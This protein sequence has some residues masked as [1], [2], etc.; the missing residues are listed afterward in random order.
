M[1]E[2]G[3][4]FDHDPKEKLDLTAALYSLCKDMYSYN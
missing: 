3:V 1:Y 4:E 2:Y